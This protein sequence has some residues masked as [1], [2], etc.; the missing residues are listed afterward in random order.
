M[1]DERACE[2]KLLKSSGLSHFHCGTLSCEAEGLQQRSIDKSA[3]CWLVG[4]WSY[5]GEIK[6]LEGVLVVP[7]AFI[8]FHN[9]HEALSTEL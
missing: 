1:I 3:G 8:S 4:L 2:R 5:L 6:L 9:R 7:A